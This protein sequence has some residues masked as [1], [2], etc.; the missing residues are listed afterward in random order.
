MVPSRVALVAL[1]VYVA[2]AVSRLGVP[3]TRFPA[4][5]F[6]VA[7]GTTAIPVF[8]A[9]GQIADIEDYT[10]FTGISP[11][12]V[13]VRHEGYACAVEHRLHEQRDW[14][15]HHQGAALDGVRVEIGLLLLSV[16]GDRVVS[17]PRIDATG[18][19]RPR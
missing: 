8:Y 14:L 12:A 9:D 13:D 2:L 4:F 1:G 10:D 5:Q 7:Q 16:Q 15:A 11:D 18:T 19:A 6:P 3:L 17:E